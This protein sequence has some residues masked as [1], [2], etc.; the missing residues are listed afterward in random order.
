MFERVLE[1]RRRFKS[2][3]EALWEEIER[4]S[5]FKSMDEALWEE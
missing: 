2:M 3:N 5:R 1:R 4:R